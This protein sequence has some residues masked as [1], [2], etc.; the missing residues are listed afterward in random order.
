M[1]LY[2][3]TKDDLKDWNPVW[4]F[5]CIKGI[6]FFTFWQGFLIE[7]LNSAGVIKPIGSKKLCIDERSRLEVVF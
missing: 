3:V 7:V 4:K 2:Y 1:K 6:I 5:L